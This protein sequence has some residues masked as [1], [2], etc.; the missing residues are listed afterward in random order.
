MLEFE[1][2]TKTCV[3][4]LKLKKKNWIKFAPSVNRRR[5]RDRKLLNAS[6]EYCNK[7]K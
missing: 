6:Q 4:I 3:V 7:T 5:R 2:D 1:D